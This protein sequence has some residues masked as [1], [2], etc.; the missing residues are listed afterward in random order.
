MSQPLGLQTASTDDA[1]ALLLAQLDA[2]ERAV[3]F[4]CRRHHL[5]PDDAD[6]FKSHVSLKFLEDDCVILRKFQGR[7]SIR[8]YLAVV[9]QRLFLDYRNAAWGKWRPSADAK[10]AGPI[11]VL[12]EQLIVRDGHTCDEACELL[13]NNHHV[14]VRRAELEILIARLPVRVRRRF[15]SEESLVDMPAQDGAADQLVVQ[16]HHRTKSEHLKHALES[17][18]AQ[19][20][21]QDRLVLKMRFE[22]GRTVAEIAT[23][24]G[25]EQKPLY[26]RLERLLTQLRSD[27]EAKGL[28]A[29]DVLDVSMTADMTLDWCGKAVQK[30]VVADPSMSLGSEE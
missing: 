23:T 14:S 11:A 3:D 12:L 26:R 6:D 5:G 27:L 16:E 20:S 8:T 21:T 10:R 9:V 2:I 18:L 29:A 7:S 1:R 22:D 15:D 24:L 13:R 19:I 4:V 25:V 17:G 28:E 30:S